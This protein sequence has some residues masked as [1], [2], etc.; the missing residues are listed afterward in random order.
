MGEKVKRNMRYY[1]LFYVMWSVLIFSFLS[2]GEKTDDGDRESRDLSEYLAVTRGESRTKYQ[3][4]VKVFPEE[5]KL[6]GVEII[7]WTNN[8]QIGIKTLNLNLFYNAFRN[9]DST[10]FK[11]TTIFKLSENKLKKYRFGNVSIQKFE[12]INRNENITGNLTYLNPDDRNKKDFTSGSF[13]LKRMILPGE[14]IWMKIKFTLT[15]PDIFYKTGQSGNY[16]FMAHWFPRI[17]VLESDG[18]WVNHQFHRKPGFYSEFSDFHVRI[19]IPEKFKIGTTGQILSKIK[20]E[21]GNIVYESIQENV[22]D[23]VWVAFPGFVEVREKVRFKGNDFDTEI[24]LLLSHGSESA[25]Q[26]YIDTIKFTLRYFEKNLSSYPYRTL[27]VVDPPLHGF[28]SAGHEFPTLITAAYLKILPSA[29]KFSELAVI[30]GIAH[31]FWYGIAGSD[32]ITE[33][34]LDEGIAVF[35][36]MEIAD[37]YFKKRGSLLSS[38]FLSISD[39]EI[40]RR[41]YISL[42]PLETSN[43]LYWNIISDRFFVGNVHSKLSLMLRSLKNTIGSKKIIGFFRY[44]F[45][46]IKFGHHNTEMFKNEFNNYFKSNYSWAFEQFVGTDKNLDTAVYSVSS[47]KIA[48][49]GNYKNEVIFVR[50]SGYFPSELSITLKNGREKK[51]FWNKNEKW[52]KLIFTANSPVNYAEVDPG[53]KIPLDINLV[54]N[55]KAV[56]KD[57]SILKILS[58]K[59]GFYFQ[60]IMTALIL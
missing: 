56:K 27:T 38:L 19:T 14:T 12:I 37:E 20:K 32:G 24:I 30:H 49:S 8:S 43:Y 45:D 16:I 33:P 9:P 15:I 40:K 1:K 34:W 47:D 5:R 46:K 29:L 35:Y 2:F 31:Q 42:S 50:K 51:L 55:S 36:E 52:K 59:I 44:Y 39:W 3:I 7:R 6:E 28:N 18:S 11:E 13:K 26:R 53:F 4:N 57:N 41:S 58:I 25:R 22:Q 21:N 48:K 23:F 10:F 54:N 17:C 60:N